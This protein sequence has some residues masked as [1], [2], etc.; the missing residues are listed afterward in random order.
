MKKFIII[1]VICFFTFGLGY[2]LDSSSAPSTKLDKETKKTASQ[3]IPVPNFIFK[4]IDG[5]E[6]KS[7]S[8]KGKVIILN[9]WASWCTPCQEEFPAMI[10]IVNSLK[11]VKLVAISNDDNEK[12]MKKFLKNLHKK[13]PIF[14]NTNILMAWDKDKD[15]SSGHFNVLRLPETFI[16]NKD[17]QITKKIIGSSQWLDGKAK[18]TIIDLLD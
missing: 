4:T 2:L 13:N 12:D 16:I 5:T 14:N 6:I 9:F 8:L 3:I 15:I 17:L 7:H 10:D 11:D 1:T 18:A